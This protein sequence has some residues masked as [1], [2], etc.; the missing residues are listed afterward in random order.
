MS[1]T[2]TPSRN[3]WRFS[4]R[5]CSIN[6]RRL[7]TTFCPV[8][9]DLDDL[10]IVGVAD[11]LLQILRRDD[12]D[13]RRRQKRFDA[14]VD[15]QAAFDDG[16]HLALDQAVVLANTLRD[17]V[18]ILAIGRFFLREH[19]HAFVVLEALEQ[20]VHFVADFERFSMSSNSDDGMTPSDL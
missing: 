13:L 16:L 2:L 18:P 19:D 3:F 20:H 12:V 6:S 1:P 4:L 9:V 8:V 11:E 14:D 17:L 10:E 15:H 7:S 5:S